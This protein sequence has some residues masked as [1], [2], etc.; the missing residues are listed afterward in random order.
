[1]K[2]LD[3]NIEL[4]EKLPNGILID[5]IRLRQVMVNLI[6][7]AVKFTDKGFVKI[8]VI[9]RNLKKLNGTISS[10]ETIDLIIN[11]HDTGKGISNKLQSDNCNTS[12]FLQ[13]IINLGISVKC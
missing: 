13:V 3:F 10:E 11:I 7:N 2:K 9:C 5:E 12:K 6:G 1:M 8:E 4:S